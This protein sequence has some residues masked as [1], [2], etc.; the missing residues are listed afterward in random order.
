MCGC[1]ISDL[2]IAR[3]LEAALPRLFVAFEYAVEVSTQVLVCGNLIGCN[4]KQLIN[5]VLPHSDGVYV[6]LHS[7]H[8]NP[9]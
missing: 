7:S 2:F 8:T 1:K 3:L 9:A 6:S 4:L 5:T